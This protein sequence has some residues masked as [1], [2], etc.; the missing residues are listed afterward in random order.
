MKTAVAALNPV[1]DARNAGDKC[2]LLK[3]TVANADN[4]I[5]RCISWLLAPMMMLSLPLVTLLPA[6]APNATLRAPIVTLPSELMPFPVF[7]KPE[8]WSGESRN[9]WRYY[10]PHSC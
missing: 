9:P 3:G 6:A 2:L 1:L 5:L 10:L 4:P 7:R 8:C